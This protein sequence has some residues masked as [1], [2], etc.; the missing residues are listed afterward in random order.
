MWAIFTA[1]SASLLG[2]MLT[3]CAVTGMRDEHGSETKISVSEGQILLG[4][5][6][7]ELSYLLH[8]ATATRDLSQISDAWLLTVATRHSA[9]RRE[10][11]L[12]ARFPSAPDRPMGRCGAGFEDYAYLLRV[13]AGAADVLDRVMLQSCLESVSIESDAPE[14]PLRRLRKEQHNGV[15]RFVRSS[16]PDHTPVLMVL[17]MAGGKLELVEAPPAGHMSPNP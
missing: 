9:T 6:T 16:P 5:P 8:D 14:D 7:T 3:A 17:R 15:L 4:D 10:R 11:I 13:T 2:I 12:I 1:S